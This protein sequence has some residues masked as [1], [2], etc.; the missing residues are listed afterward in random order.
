MNGVASYTVPLRLADLPAM[1]SII[2]PAEEKTNI[3]VLQ[4][5][6]SRGRDFHMNGA[7]MLFVS[8]RG[9]NL[10]FSPNLGCSGVNAIIFS[11]KPK[12]TAIIIVNFS[13][14]VSRTLKK[15]TCHLV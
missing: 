13:G 10:G 2:I 8:L 11:R 15:I 3:Y 12:P 6:K 14:C 4:L 7:G 5:E 1:L 9:V